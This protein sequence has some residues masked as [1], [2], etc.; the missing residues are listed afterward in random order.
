MS[1]ETQGIDPQL[2]LLL[3]EIKGELGGI[4]SQVKAA[5]EATN[6]RIEDLTKA[7]NQRIDDHQEDVEKRL[8]VVDSRLLEI[9]KEQKVSRRNTIIT[10]GG[11]AAIASGMA[12]VIKAV[13]N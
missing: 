3:G 1:E 13:A 4:R 8:Q 7:V 5:N 6:H 12:E 10:S 11:V 9:E 2:L